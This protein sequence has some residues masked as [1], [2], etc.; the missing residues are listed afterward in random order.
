MA[1]EK[2]RE[3]ERGAQMGNHIFSAFSKQAAI[4]KGPVLFDATFSAIN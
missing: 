2:V 4:G 1:A 3:P